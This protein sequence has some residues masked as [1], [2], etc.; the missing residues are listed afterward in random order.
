MLLHLHDI[1]FPDGTLFLQMLSCLG[2]IL[3]SE[4]YKIC[5]EDS[6]KYTSSF[7]I[8]FC[9][10]LR[11]ITLYQFFPLFPNKNYLLLWIYWY[12]FRIKK[13]WQSNFVKSWWM[14]LRDAWWLN[15]RL[16]VFYR[17]EES[18]HWWS[19]CHLSWDHGHPCWC[20]SGVCLQDSSS[21]NISWIQ[22]SRLEPLLSWLDWKNENHGG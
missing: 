5:T 17:L 13:N 18:G 4:T 8:L 19:S 6:L 16:V 14:T 3:L 22:S 9:N 11:G 20:V 7:V 12:F 15:K 21:S 1:Y 2:F 10:E